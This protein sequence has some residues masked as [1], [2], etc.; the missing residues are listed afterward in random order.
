[1]ERRRFDWREFLILWAA[2]VVGVLAIIPYTLH[3]Q[4][5][6]REQ[7]PSL[8]G[9][10]GVQ[11]ALNGLLV[12]GAVALGLLAAGR[13]GLG[14]PLLEAA[15]DRQPLTRLRWRL[16]PAL[17]WGAAAAVAI[18]LLD[19]LFSV[20]MPQAMPGAGVTTPP[21][22]QGLLAS[23]YGGITEELLLRLFMMSLLAWLLGRVWRRGPGQPAVGALWTANVLAALLFGAGHLPTA[24]ALM[25]LSGPVVLRIVLLNSVAGVAFGYLYW[26]RG[27]ESAMLAHFTADI[28]LHVMLPLW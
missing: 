25:P 5:I 14:A 11:M 10:L 26:T 28:I 20:V 23:F 17:P 19:V 21:A 22:W 18:I 3:L 6:G 16:L 7:L 4:G 15:L 2:G 8:G 9:L 12:G 27:L 13:S 24:A 1:M